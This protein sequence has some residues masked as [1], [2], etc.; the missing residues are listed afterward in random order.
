MLMNHDVG[1]SIYVNVTFVLVK[2]ETDN[3]SREKVPLKIK[4]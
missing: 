1:E 3:Q 2:S 4:E